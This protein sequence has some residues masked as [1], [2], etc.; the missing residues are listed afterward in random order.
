MTSLK[1]LTTLIGEEMAS[2]LYQKLDTI[3]ESVPSFKLSGLDIVL[4]KSYFLNENMYCQIIGQ[5]FG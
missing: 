4:L 5:A 1:C 2:E 3:T